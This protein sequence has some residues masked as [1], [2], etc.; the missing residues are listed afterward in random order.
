MLRCCWASLGRRDS[1]SLR[2]L[3]PPRESSVEVEVVED[4]Q[5]PKRLGG[6]GVLVVV[7]LVADLF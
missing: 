5:L 6:C 3:I 4:V 7:V 2:D 1:A